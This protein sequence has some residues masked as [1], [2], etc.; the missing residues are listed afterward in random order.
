MHENTNRDQVLMNHGLTKSSNEVL[1]IHFQQIKDSTLVTTSIFC[2]QSVPI[3]D[4]PC[5]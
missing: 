1:S 3:L 4:Q 2:I 5:P